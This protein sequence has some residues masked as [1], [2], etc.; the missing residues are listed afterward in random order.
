MLGPQGETVL[1][2]GHKIRIK[3][4]IWKLITFTPSY[5]VLHCFVA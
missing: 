1:K 2:M 3:G 5:L 4:A